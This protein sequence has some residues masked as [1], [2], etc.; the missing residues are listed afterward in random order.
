VGTIVGWLPPDDEDAALWR[1]IHDDG[2]EEDLDEQEVHDCVCATNDSMLPSESDDVKDAEI[3]DNVEE[4]EELPEIALSY[5]NN[6]SGG[7]GLRNHQIDI[8]GLIQD[9]LMKESC[10]LEGLK[11]R[12]SSFVKDK[13]KSWEAL[14]RNAED[15][16]SLRRALI[17]LEEAIHD[18]Q[19]SPDELDEVA[20]D[21]R[22]VMAADGWVFDSEVEGR[23]KLTAMQL[24][25]D[26]AA[27]AGASQELGGSCLN[28]RN[29]T[30]EDASSLQK[31][32]DECLAECE[33][34]KEGFSFIGKRVRKFFS[35]HGISDGNIVGYLRGGLNDGVSLWHMEHDD[36]DCEDLDK[37]DL[38]RAMG[39]FESNAQE[40][41]YCE[42]VNDDQCGSSDGSIS[43]EDEEDESDEEEE[44]AGTSDVLW[45]SLNVRMRWLSAV[46]ASCT[47]SE[48]S[49]ALSA[50]MEY[51]KSFGI[52]SV[53]SL[54]GLG[55]KSKISSRS[56]SRHTTSAYGQITV[57][58]TKKFR[59]GGGGRRSST[60]AAQGNKRVLRDRAARHLPDKLF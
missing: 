15:V 14:V 22:K 60:K 21:K 34:L 23:V 53:D 40:D 44:S 35:G 49:L 43:E 33:H 42:D 58:S 51:S 18:T 37:T 13:K 2:D 54:D 25:A 38:V 48:L 31:Y 5:Y 55:S 11:L 45:P 4:H 17:D 39:H 41:D 56:P 52:I 9:L 12:G 50:L 8:A 47:I 29:G 1:V 6:A 10:L 20:K 24:A 7:M 59:T 46:N 32:A 57:G 36:G 3:R 19:E 27:A 16:S 28:R 30:K 26:E